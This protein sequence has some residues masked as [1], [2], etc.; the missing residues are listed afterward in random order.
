M[1]TQSAVQTLIQ[2]DLRFLP[3]CCTVTACAAYALYPKGM[4]LP[5]PDGLSILQAAARV[6]SK[7]HPGCGYGQ[8]VHTFIEGNSRSLQWIAQELAGVIPKVP[9]PVLQGFLLLARSG[10][11]CAPDTQ[12]KWQGGRIYK[13]H[14][15]TGALQ[16]ATT[17][18]T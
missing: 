6:Y 9:Q 1:P 17:R 4:R 2:P 13:A 15:R 16:A 14:Q 5:G 18:R 3:G 11:L 7:R 12:D 10:W 8:I